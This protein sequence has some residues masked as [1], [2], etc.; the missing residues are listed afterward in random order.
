MDA[1]IQGLILTKFSGSLSD[2]STYMN[3]MIQAA[4]VLIGGIVIWRASI[5]LHKKKMAKRSRKQFF[6]TSYSKGWKRK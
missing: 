3:L 6:E 4:A 5:V 2:S 1:D